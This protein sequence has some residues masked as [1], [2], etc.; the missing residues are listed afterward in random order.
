LQ[1]AAIREQLDK[2]VNALMRGWVNI[3]IFRQGN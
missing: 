3:V 2:R 1:S